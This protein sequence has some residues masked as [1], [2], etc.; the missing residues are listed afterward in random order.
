MVHVCVT[1][2]DLHLTGLRYGSFY[3][4]CVVEGNSKLRTNNSTVSCG[5]TAYLRL[6]IYQ[7]SKALGSLQAKPKRHLVLALVN[8]VWLLPR[9]Y[10]TLCSLHSQHG[11]FPFSSYLIIRPLI[12]YPFRRHGAA[13]PMVIYTTRTVSGKHSEA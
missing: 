9:S 2:R 11:M 8:C 7:D 3:S 13:E 4:I 1:Y 12:E 6:W 5:C 10:Q